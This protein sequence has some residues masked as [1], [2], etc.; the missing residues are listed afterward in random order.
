MKINKI[1][2]LEKP[3]KEFSMSISDMVTIMGGN[4][5]YCPGT[6]QDGGWFGDDYCSASYS[7]GSCGSASDYCGSY[8]SCTFNLSS[9]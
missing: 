3:K 9:K 2:L 5:D 1:R 7:S 4:S 8:T 6:Y